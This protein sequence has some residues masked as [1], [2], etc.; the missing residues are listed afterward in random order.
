MKKISANKKK[1]LVLASMVVLLVVAG[2]LNFV[3][4]SNLPKQDGGTGGDVTTT[5]FSALRTTRESKRAEQMAYY[6]AIIQ[7]ESSTAEAIGSAEEAMAAL[8]K[9]IETELSIENVIMSNGYA[10]VVV[11]LSDKAVHVT[12]NKSSLESIDLENVYQA[13]V[14]NSN[15]TTSQV[16]IIPYA[17]AQ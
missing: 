9:Q 1:I 11:T 17:E 5:F 8:T 10:D 3:L 2:T 16:T 13:V 6:K 15:Y 4:N 12:L 7:D 14:D